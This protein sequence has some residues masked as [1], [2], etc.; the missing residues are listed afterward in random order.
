MLAN[1]FFMI[2]MECVNGMTGIKIKAGNA[3]VL[4]IKAKNG[5]LGCS[6]FSVETANRIGDALAIVSGV[7]EFG[8]MLEAEVKSVSDKARELGIA[9]GM[10]GKDALNLMNR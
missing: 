10:K 4:L 6:Y 9:I 3:P 8:D 5:F 2:L 1:L 7:S